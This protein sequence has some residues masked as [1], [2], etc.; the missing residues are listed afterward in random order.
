MTARLGPT[1]AAAKASAV[2]RT[3]W[4]DMLVG[5]AGEDPP[6]S[7]FSAASDWG[8]I[9]SPPVGEIKRPIRPIRPK[10]RKH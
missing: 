6:A 9:F 2:A 10:A 5:Q 8:K 3:L 1:S 4:R 7:D